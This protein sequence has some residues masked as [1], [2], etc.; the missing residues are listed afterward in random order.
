MKFLKGLNP[1]FEG[2]TAASLHQ[3]TTPSLRKTIVAMS[4]E[5]V[6][7]K[8]TKGRHSVPCPVFYSIDIRE[9]TECLWTEGALEASGV[10][11]LSYLLGER[12]IHIWQRKEEVMVEVVDNN[13]DG[14]MNSSILHLPRHIWQQLKRPRLVSQGQ[15]K[16][17]GQK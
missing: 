9:T 10:P 1:E 8:M 6:R 16:E 2:R 14:N 4:R 7:L 13:M 5:E 17:G 11:P 12:R 15:S 3:T